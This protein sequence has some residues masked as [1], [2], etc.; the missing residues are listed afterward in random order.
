MNELLSLS[1]ESSWVMVG[2]GALAAYL[3]TLIYT[4]LVRSLQEKKFQGLLAIFAGISFVTL[5][6]VFAAYQSSYERGTV[7][8]YAMLIIPMAMVSLFHLRNLLRSRRP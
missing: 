3:I 5:A 6:Y 7:G 2:W 1:G 8:S 4:A